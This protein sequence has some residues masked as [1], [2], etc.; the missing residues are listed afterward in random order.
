MSTDLDEIPIL[1]RLTALEP[2]LELIPPPPPSPMRRQGTDSPLSGEEADI[3]SESDS[4][5]ES[6]M[7]IVSDTK[8]EEEMAPPT[9]L[10]NSPVGVEMPG[11]IWLA[12][13]AL[14]LAYLWG[15]AYAVSPVR[16]ISQ[17]RM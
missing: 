5:S 8:E 16:D 9:D 12:G 17:R 3:D 6:D 13:F 15:V 2:E 14:M 11:W 4:E 1:K 10:L 7:E